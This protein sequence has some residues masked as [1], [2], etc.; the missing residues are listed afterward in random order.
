M[1]VALLQSAS[2]THPDLSAEWVPDP[3][4][5]RVSKVLKASDPGAPP[6]PPA[7]SGGVP[8][9]PR[10]R[11]AHNE[12]SV[13]LEYIGHDGVPISSQRLTTDGAEN[14]NERA[15][16]AMIQR[17]TSRW[18]NGALTTQWR[19]LRGSVVF[20]SGVDVWRLS[21]NGTTLTLRSSLEDS[22]SKSET[23]TVYRRR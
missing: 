1:L 23:T 11:R 17:S 8:Q 3:S 20:I 10:L 19:L 7:P 12:P 21:E 2:V 13:V 6:A 16:G 18:E 14:V 15:G 9:L 5:Y 4:Q 22:K